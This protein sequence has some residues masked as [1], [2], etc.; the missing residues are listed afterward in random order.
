MAKPAKIAFLGNCQTETLA[1]LTRLMID[2]V[3]TIIFDY[4]EPSSHD[5][6]VAERFADSLADCDVVMTMRTSTRFRHTN[7]PGLRARYPDKTIVIG[8]FYF[9]GLFPDACYVG[10]F[11]NRFED[12]T[13][14]NSV[15]LLDAFRRGLPLDEAVR[16]LRSI[17]AFER[18]G[19]MDAWSSSMEEMRRR[20]L[21]NVLDVPVADMMEDACRR[22]PAFLTMNHPTI[23][24]VHEH[25]EEV[26]RFASIAYRPVNVAR[27]R[28]PLMHHDTTPVLDAVA[29]HFRLPYRTAQ[30]WKINALDQRFVDAEELAA[31]FYMAYAQAE[32][33]SLLVHSPG[34]MVATLRADPVHAY[35]VTTDAAPP[36]AID[37]APIAVA[38]RS[39]LLLSVVDMRNATRE[40]IAVLKQV[41]GLTALMDPKVERIS[42]SLKLQA[43]LHQLAEVADP[44]IENLN[45]RLTQLA[46]RVRLYG[47]A[48]ALLGLLVLIACLGLAV[49]IFFLL[50]LA[51]ASP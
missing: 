39:S 19:L 10:D 42:E 33:A 3:S 34:D 25:L 31:Q 49:E 18:L 23:A 38:E 44:K 28:D 36:V 12:P 47:R 5:E 15:I 37:V 6:A 40:N 4:A 21:N 9:R 17:A 48:Q 43:R 46:R 35:L 50:R 32:A 8:N 1:F 7:D 16:E 14:I 22:Y 20:E 29:E 11:D 30:R 27:L 2:D 13:A 41:H 24:L 26:F 45:H 51:A